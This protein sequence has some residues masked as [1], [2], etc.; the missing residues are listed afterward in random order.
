MYV[1]L[2]VDVFDH[3]PNVYPVLVHP[4]VVSAFSTSY[5]CELS[6]VELPPPLQLYCTVYLC[7]VLEKLAVSVVFDVIVPLV[8]DQLE[9]LVVYP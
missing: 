1:A 3:P 4:F 7:A 5:V 2:P 8:D 9:K 6:D